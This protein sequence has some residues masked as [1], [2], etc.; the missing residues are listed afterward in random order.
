MRREADIVSDMRGG[1]HRLLSRASSARAVLAL[2]A[3]HEPLAPVHLATCWS[4]LGRA[5]GSELAHLRRGGGKRLE[6]LRRA[7]HQ[8]LRRLDAKGVATLAHALGR[9]RLCGGSETTQPWSELWEGLEEAALRCAAR[10]T[11][12]PQGLSNTAWSHAKAGRRAPALFDALAR[13]AERQADGFNSRDHAITAWAFASAAH[14]APSL[15]D[16]I[17]ARAGAAPLLGQC[18]E[19]SLSNL[20]WSFAT[21]GHEASELLDAIA[22][23]AAPRLPSFSGQ[24]RRAHCRAHTA[25][26]ARDAAP[27]DGAVP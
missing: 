26:T 20:A 1:L 9:L 15:F 16:A 19:Q 2:H 12:T 14:A 18:S 10:Q 22:G 3:A 21:A 13:E 23:E 11:F 27:K 25:S 24:A 4:R 6:A 17:A 8:S 7:T 5:T